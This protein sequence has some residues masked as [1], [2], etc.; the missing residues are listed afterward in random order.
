MFLTNHQ[1]LFYSKDIFQM[2]ETSKGFYFQAGWESQCFFYPFRVVSRKDGA[3]CNL[4]LQVSCPL[5]VP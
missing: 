3:P 2:I 4:G 1:E 5:V